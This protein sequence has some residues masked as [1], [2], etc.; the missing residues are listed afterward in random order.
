MLA[1]FKNKITECEDLIASAHR[2]DPAGVPF[3]SGVHQHQITVAAF[4]NT[5]IA[6]ETFI[7]SS[8]A[9]LMIGSPTISGV[10]P[11]KFVAPVDLL[12]ARELV[13]GMMKYFDY[14]NHQNVKKLVCMYFQ[15]GYPF[16]PYISAIYSELDDLRTMRNASAHISST[17]QT[18]IEALALRL[19]S[20][21][22]P[23]ISLYQLLTAINP[24]SP[25]KTVFAFYKEKLVVTAELIS[26]G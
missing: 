9:Q 15:K 13:I 19:F 2:V 17:T 8:L 6:W 12:A 26:Q 5:F 22:K 20:S 11:I 21:P 24:K 3:F 23:G 18:A 7:E 14:G 10:L 25:S 16:E 1:D 4:L